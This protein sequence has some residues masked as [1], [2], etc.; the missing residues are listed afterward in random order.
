MVNQIPKR[1]RKL[2][3]KSVSVHNKQ[4]RPG[5]CRRPVSRLALRRLV[6]L[7]RLQTESPAVGNLRLQFTINDENHMPLRAP[8]IGF[9]SGR[10]LH[11]AYSDLP[12]VLC[13]PECRARLAGVLGRRYHPPVCRRETESIHLHDGSIFTSRAPA[14]VCRPRSASFILPICLKPVDSIRSNDFSCRNVH[15][16]PTGASARK[17]TASGLV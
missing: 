13:P 14:R 11:H 1:N 15:F 3:P 7:S 12:E 6:T 16:N 2:G 8:V 5:S 9:I 4:P 17:S 10:I